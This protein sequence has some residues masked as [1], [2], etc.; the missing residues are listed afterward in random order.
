MSKFVAYVASKYS[1]D[2]GEWYVQQN[3]Q[4]SLAVTRELWKMGFAPIS[5]LGSSAHMGGAGLSWEDFLE[6]DCEILSRC[7]F[8]VV[9]PN[10]TSSKGAQREVQEAKS[11]G[12]GVFLWGN[13]LDMEALRRT[14]DSGE[15]Q[16][17]SLGA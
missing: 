9:L 4:E 13:R 11:L 7:D 15:I 2:R 6:G 17:S 14:F 10:W 12:K 3:I 8:L 5:P 1:D 16:P